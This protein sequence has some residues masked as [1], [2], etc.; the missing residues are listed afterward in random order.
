MTVSLGVDGFSGRVVDTVLW[1]VPLYRCF[2]LKTLM[3]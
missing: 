3:V 1:V 2:I